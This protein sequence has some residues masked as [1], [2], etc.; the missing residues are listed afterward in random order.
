MLRSRVTMLLLGALMVLLMAS[1]SLASTP[2]ERQLQLLLSQRR[3]AADSSLLESQSLTDAEVFAEADAWL[4]S[5][6]EAEQEEAAHAVEAAAEAASLA[7]PE[8]LAKHAKV[9]RSAGKK[10]AAAGKAGSKKKSK[11]AP[12]LNKLL[13]K[14]NHDVDKLDA[15]LFRKRKSAGGKYKV[16]HQVVYE[17]QDH[18]VAGQKARER[19]IKA[20]AEDI[21]D[22]AKFGSIS[23]RH[24]I[25]ARD[26]HELADRTRE[27]FHEHQ[28]E[29]QTKQLIRPEH[30]FID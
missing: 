19:Q 5:L 2:G 26:A 25:A 24:L 21:E 13:H 1:G 20:V 15:A 6:S 8:R 17:G 27:V 23:E 14:I 11:K 22:N 28:E 16:R 29:L 10:R 9:A 4:G 30:R 18:S 12:A 7:P 3:A